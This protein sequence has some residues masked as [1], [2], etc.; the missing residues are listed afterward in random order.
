MTFLGWFSL[1][2]N[3][4]LIK[5]CIWC[6]FWC[7]FK[8]SSGKWKHTVNLSPVQISKTCDL[9]QWKFLPKPFLRHFK[10]MLGDKST[11]NKG[12]VQP[13]KIC[14]WFSNSCNK[15]SSSYMKVFNVY[16]S[17]KVSHAVKRHLN[18]TEAKLTLA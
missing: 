4:F 3:S 7:L 6:C 10:I 11:E 14:F 17:H 8:C 12:L 9:N 1:T 13:Y 15:K 18:V 2:R 5:W 16:I